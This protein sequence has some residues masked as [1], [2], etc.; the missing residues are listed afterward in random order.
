MNSRKRPGRP[1]GGYLTKALMLLFALLA[2][3]F[4]LR[5]AKE[6][7]EISGWVQE[8]KL[9]PLEKPAPVAGPEETFALT[10]MSAVNGR[11]KAL[12]SQ[13][14][15]G[16]QAQQGG[17]SLKSCSDHLHDPSGAC[18]SF[19][20]VLAKCLRVS[21]IEV[22]KVGLQRGQAKAL[23]HVLEAKLDGRWVLMDPLFCQT[24]RGHD[25][26]LAGASAVSK[27]WAF[28]S[29][30]LTEGY[31]RSFDYSGFYYTNWDRIP[32]LGW[33]VKSIPGLEGEMERRGV[34]VRMWF[35]DINLWLA[36]IC[37]LFSLC[38]GWWSHRRRKQAASV[39]R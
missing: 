8:V 26:C 1:L 30:Q 15:T 32:L 4:F 2:G 38:L 34:S 24:F 11:L 19:S 28:F 7:S 37:L 33:V 35:L 36:G 10:M 22:R 17:M 9:G 14:K 16:E 3:L 6:E 21:G 29:Q 13:G 12:L 5:E 25:G 39:P 23:H 27:D 20:H 31:D 18:A